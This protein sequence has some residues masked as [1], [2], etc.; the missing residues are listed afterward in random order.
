MIPGH[1]QHRLVDSTLTHLL[2][3]SRSIQGDS[4]ICHTKTLRYYI[5][6]QSHISCILGIFLLS[7]HKYL[8]HI[9][10]ITEKLPHIAMRSFFSLLICSNKT[11]FGDNCFPA[12]E[13]WSLGGHNSTAL[14]IFSIKMPGF[15]C[16]WTLSVLSSHLKFMIPPQR[17]KERRVQRSF[18]SYSLVNM[19]F[20]ALVDR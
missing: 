19:A 18:S 9:Y 17:S 14:V 6:F 3:W 10:I 4:W 8:G 5:T 15:H 2:Q 16:L 7:V 12:S 11:L 13:L 1:P 20:L